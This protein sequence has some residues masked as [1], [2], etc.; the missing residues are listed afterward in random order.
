MKSEFTPGPWEQL[1]E[2]LEIVSVSASD[3]PVA[4]VHR[5]TGGREARATAR[6]IAAAPELLNTSSA[7]VLAVDEIIGAFKDVLD[8]ESEPGW[9]ADLRAATQPTRAAITKATGQ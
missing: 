5:G 2:T 8:T 6:L 9:I 3:A 4:S 7:L 1:P